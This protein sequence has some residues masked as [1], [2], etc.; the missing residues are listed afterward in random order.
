MPNHKSTQ[1]GK[2]WGAWSALMILNWV[3]MAAVIGVAWWVDQQVAETVLGAIWIL[4]S[5]WGLGA[6]A[7]TIRLSGLGPGA[8]PRAMAIAA[9]TLWA[10]SLIVVLGL[11]IGFPLVIL[12]V[13]LPLLLGRPWLFW[14]WLVVLLPTL[15]FALWDWLQ[16]KAIA[17]S[18]N[19]LGW[20]LAIYFYYFVGFNALILLTIAFLLA[21]GPVGFVV[22]LFS[23]ADLLWHWL[24]GGGDNHL[25]LLCFWLWEA[26]WFPFH[27]NHCGFLLWGFHLGHLLLFAL[28]LRYGQP[29][30]NGVVDRYGQGQRWLRDRLSP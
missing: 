17:R 27:V 23:G 11:G 12:L 29:C 9:G 14:P 1:Q 8:N 16:A 20:L 30:F 18:F 28:A 2:H 26:P 15:S 25:P 3:L 13:Q 24:Q 21:L 4:V 10:W 7:V 5:L 19:N 6:I 22:Q